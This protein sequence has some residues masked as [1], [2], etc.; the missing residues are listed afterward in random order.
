VLSLDRFAWD[1]L[2]V[3]PDPVADDALIGE[4][5]A[6]A[7][8]EPGPSPMVAAARHPLGAT[9][10]ILGVIIVLAMFALRPTG[11]SREEAGEALRVLGIPTEFVSGSVLE[12]ADHACGYDPNEDCQTV[13]FEITEGSDAGR[14]VVQM[15]TGGASP[16]FTVGSSVVLAYV[17]P[18]GLVESIETLPCSFDP[19]QSCEIA[20]ITLLEASEEGR[21]ITTEAPEGT[22]DLRVG[23]DADVFLDESG[24]VLG[25]GASDVTSQYRFSDFER[26]NVLLV[27]LVVFAVA[28]IA[29]GRWRGVAALAALGATLVVVLVWLLPAILDG[30][31]TVLVAIVGASAVAYLALYMSHGFNLMTTVA[32]FGT[33]GALA[34]TAFLSWATV[35]AAHFT[36]FATEESTLLVLFNG[37]DIGGLVLAGMVLGAAGALDDVTIT[38]ASSVWQMKSINPTTPAPELLRRGMRIGQD[39][40]GSTVNTLLLAYLGA[41]LPLAILLALAQ[42]PLG[43]IANSEVVAIEIV[44]TLVGSIGLVAAVPITTWL[45]VKTVSPM[46]APPHEH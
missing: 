22:S 17:A 8:V 43:A 4:W 20:T 41:S 39:H 2:R 16:S 6:S 35:E 37:V 46:D 24:G 12:V 45:A 5:L 32:L 10:L 21:S 29:L 7:P 31:N 23:G 25:A 34:L 1:T 19:E 3:D 38:Q 30:R 14:L 33:I 44:R 9:A 28:V 42:Q 40:I 13:Q 18:N 11:V 27:V 26:S 15:F 36:G